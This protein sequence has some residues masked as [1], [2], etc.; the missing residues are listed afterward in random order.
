M[1]LSRDV[2]ATRVSGDS[3][4]FLAAVGSGLVA[5]LAA[6]V[7][8]ARLL[9]PADRGLYSIVMLLVAIT[10]QVA[11]AGLGDAALYAVAGRH[12][13]I[14]EEAPY[15]VGT[16]IAAGSLG[17]VLLLPLVVGLVGGRGGAADALAGAVV[18]AT[19][20]LVAVLP[21]L[22]IAVGQTRRGSLIYACNSIA[23]AISL[24][25]VLSVHP[26]VS[27]AVL[28]AVP[29]NVLTLALLTWSLRRSQVPLRP[30]F[31]V[32]HAGRLLRYGGP[33]QAGLLLNSLAARVDLLLVY[34]FL[35]S[36]AAGYYSVALTLSVV[37][38]SA[39]VSLTHGVFPRLP[40][41]D[42]SAAKDLG[43]RAVRTVLAASVLI[44]PAL[45]LASPVAIPAAFGE[46]FRA[47]VLPSMLLVAAGVLTGLQWLL[48]RMA[49]AR[50]AAV[51]L[52]LSFSAFLLVM[53]AFDCLTVP[54]LGLVA[55]AWGSVLGGATGVI[56]AWVALRRLPEGRFPLR[57]TLPRA[58]DFRRLLLPFDRS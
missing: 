17:A 22:L 2:S 23:L 45:W 4:A 57:S 53:V 44:A 6:S 37:A 7:A 20:V 16:A 18:V 54:R 3:L 34:W 35:G 19:A 47:A 13:S 15:A 11:T 28:A 5:G 39:A 27:F 41:L 12:T 31:D 48:S 52:P 33:V 25:A 30:R 9:G 26:T 21:S 10:S 56:A 40:G 24:V 55:A 38:S 58:V 51:A 29:A 46:A 32:R 42:P 50:G 8:S 49:A 14:E 1:H 36:A 43:E